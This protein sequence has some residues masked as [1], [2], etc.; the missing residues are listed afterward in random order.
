MAL[1]RLSERVRWLVNDLIPSLG[2]KASEPFLLTVRDFDRRFQAFIEAYLYTD[3]PVPERRRWLRLLFEAEFE[4]YYAHAM[5]IADPKRKLDFKTSVGE[6][7]A[8]GKTPSVFKYSA[9]GMVA[10]GVTGLVLGYKGRDRE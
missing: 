2:T 4:A 1:L 7:M 5:R 3:T 6:I 9:T 8:A 10:A